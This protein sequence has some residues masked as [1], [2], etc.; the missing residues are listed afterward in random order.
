MDI[1]SINDQHDPE[2]EARLTPASFGHWHAYIKPR[3]AEMRWT[4]IPWETDLWAARLKAQRLE[5]PIFL[6]AMNGNPLGC[7]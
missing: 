4:V 2:A 5:K 7:V 6:W 1:T 3:P